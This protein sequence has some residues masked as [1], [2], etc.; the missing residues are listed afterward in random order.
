MT[1]EELKAAFEAADSEGEFL[2]FDRVEPKLNRR[3]DM[4]AFLLLDQLVP[5][6]RDMVS[7]AGHDGVG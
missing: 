5:G 1:F 3:P 4:H 6:D 7:G 2:E